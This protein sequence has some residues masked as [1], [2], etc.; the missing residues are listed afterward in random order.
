[1]GTELED[2][3]AEALE[4]HLADCPECGSLASQERR[5]DDHLGQAMRAVTIPVGLR[6]RLVNK[7]SAERDAW[8]RRWLLRGV[9]VAAVAAAILL[10]V[11]RGLNSLRPEV[12]LAAV[13]SDHTRD[14]FSPGAIEQWFQDE[15]NVRTF[16]PSPNDLKYQWLNHYDLVEFGTTGKR[17]P[18]LLFT[19]TG[20]DGLAQAQVFILKDTD[21]KGLQG[22]VGQVVKGSKGY[23][24]RVLRNQDHPHFYYVVMYTERSASLFFVARQPPAV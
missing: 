5:L 17:V 13:V 22:L 15:R 21:F 24:V 8:Y 7:L 20:N 12:E 9:A 2:S 10:L 19:Y 23:E 3:E 16:V 18:W 4:G 1:V 14:G 6:D 11:W